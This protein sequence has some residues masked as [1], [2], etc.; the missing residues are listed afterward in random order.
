MAAAQALLGAPIARLPQARQAQLDVVMSEW[1]A[2]MASRVDFPETH[3][4]LAGVALTLRAL[5]QAE[6]AFREAVQLD[7]Q[8]VEAW[9]MLVRLAAATRGT[10]AATTVIEQALAV[11]PDDDSLVRLR[12]E[13]LALSGDDQ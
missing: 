6:A 11:L 10:E 8:R 2:A 12:E 7:P 5:P 1:R 13:V 9:I 3:L 4:Q